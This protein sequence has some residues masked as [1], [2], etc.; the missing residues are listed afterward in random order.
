MQNI[1]MTGILLAAVILAAVL[2]ACGS[3]T[4][5]DVD[6]VLSRP[7]DF[8]GS[9]TCEQCHLEHFDSWKMIQHSRMIQDAQKNR[10]VI[11][12]EIDE[13]E[14]R[15]DLAKLEDDLKIPDYEIYIPLIRFAGTPTCVRSATRVPA[16]RMPNM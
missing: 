8:V 11:I 16:L 14:I 13:E 12:A 2:S 15:K 1:S 3:E 10:D 6:E 7:K 5:V 9:D 4:A